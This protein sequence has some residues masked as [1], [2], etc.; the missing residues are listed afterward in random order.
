MMR[1]IVGMLFLYLFIFSCKNEKTK[2][3][4]LQQEEVQ[5]VQ[6]RIIASNTVIDSFVTIKA[7]RNIDG[8]TVFYT[9]DGTEP[10]KESTKFSGEIKVKEPK[11]LKF[12]AFHN[13]FKASETASIKLYQK[14]HSA[15]S[16]E[17]FTNVNKKYLG[18]GNTTVINGKKASLEYNNS[19]WMGFDT[20]AKATVKFDKKTYLKSIDIGY[21]NDPGSWIFPPSEI[22][23]IV[24]EK[25]KLTFQLEPLKTLTDREMMNFTV[26][27]NQE[28]STLHISIKNVEQIPDWHEGNGNKAWLFMDEWIFN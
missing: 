5:L 22:K 28:V 14:G 13:N 17:W 6:P 11:E 18:S 12:K 23:V 20:I 8:T 15:N 25:D 19:Q 26:P 4:Y 21:L 27:I 9:E 2:I 1:K 3:N 10:T 7:D 16:I 24:N